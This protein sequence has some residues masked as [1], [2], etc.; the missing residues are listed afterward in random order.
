MDYFSI[1]RKLIFTRNF[2]NN[3]FATIYF[4]TMKFC[5]F[6]N[7]KL[8]IINIIRLAPAPLEMFFERNNMSLL[9]NLKYNNNTRNYFAPEEPIVKIAH[10][11]CFVLNSDVLS[12]KVEFPPT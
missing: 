10:L 9:S 3:L 2:T 7:T 5:I 8:M 4:I 6:E 1:T 12:T 11:R